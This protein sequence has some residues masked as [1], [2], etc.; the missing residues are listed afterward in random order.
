MTVDVGKWLSELGLARYAPAFAENDVDSNVLAELDEKDL[1]K[2]GIVSLGHRK[3]LLKAI[4]ALDAATPAVGADTAADARDTPPRAAKE[5]ERRQITLLFCDLVGSTALSRQLDPEDLRGLMRRYQ[6]AVAG[7]MTR[8]GG[9]VAQYLGDGVLAYF[10]WPQA[11]EDQAD[12]AV[13]AGLDAVQAVETLHGTGA[14]RLMAR[15]GV[16]T[17]EVV[18]GDLVGEISRDA[19]A[20]SGETPNLAARLQQ[21]AMPGDVVIGPMTRRLVGEAF[22]L[23]DR[24][25]QRLKG[26]GE[27]VATWAVIG[28][29]RSESRFETSRG[30]STTSLF[31]REHELGM[32]RDRWEQCKADGG[33]VVVLSGEAGIGKSRLVQSLRDHVSGEQCFR[34]RYQCSPH[35]L[36]SAFYPIIRRLERAAR[37]A[38]E[39]GDDEKLGACLSN[40]FFSTTVRESDSMHSHEQD[41]SRLAS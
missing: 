9:H 4:A 31:G 25:A 34:L 19:E 35:H 2:L 37:F 32:L 39:D 17:G 38:E 26:F 7:A 10:G 13:R 33:Q 27:P 8:Y 29:V 15:V 6:D 14:R 23:E 24:G 5:A 3:K 40:R 21:A 1:E 12:R 36:N 41:I 18:V 11:F 30:D 20:V 22:V 28:E 16:E